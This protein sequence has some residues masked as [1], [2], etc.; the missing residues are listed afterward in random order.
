M[1]LFSRYNSSVGF[2]RLV[3]YQGEAQSRAGLNPI[4]ASLAS[5][6]PNTGCCCWAPSPLSRPF[7]ARSSASCSMTRAAGPLVEAEG[8]RLHPPFRGSNNGGRPTWDRRRC[9]WIILTAGA[10]RPLTSATR[11]LDEGTRRKTRPQTQGAGREDRTGPSEERRQR[12]HPLRRALR[13]SALCQAGRQGAQHFRHRA[14][15]TDRV[16][17]TTRQLSR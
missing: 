5:L 1:P 2:A 6:P 9:R 14:T 10:A 3:C 17:I 8:S 12:S 4:A 15:D 11:H 7:P 16:P 13:C